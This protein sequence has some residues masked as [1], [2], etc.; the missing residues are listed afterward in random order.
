MNSA[1]V[2]LL[3]LG[4]KWEERERRILG[5]GGPENF[6]DEGLPDKSSVEKNG[7]AR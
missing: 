3:F 7:I 5:P 4:D 1:L 6:E 2:P